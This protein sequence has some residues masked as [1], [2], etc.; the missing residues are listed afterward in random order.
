MERIQSSVDPEQ[1]KITIGNCGWCGLWDSHLVDVNCPLC[2][3]K[4]K[5]IGSVPVVKGAEISSLKWRF[6]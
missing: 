6:W 4:S 1:A 2:D 3:F 5:T